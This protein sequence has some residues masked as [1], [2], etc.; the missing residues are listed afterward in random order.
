MSIAPYSETSEP[1]PPLAPARPARAVVAEPAPL[2][3]PKSFRTMARIGVAM[4]LHDKLK[5]AGILIGVVFS[6][7][8]SNFQT[9]LFLGLLL[10]NTMFVDRADADVWIVPPQ[11]NVLQGG[12]GTFSDTSVAAARAVTGV[13]WS[14]PLIMG[15]AP[16]RLPVGG[17]RPVTL[18][19]TQLPAAHGG[20]FHIVKGETASL[21]LPDAIF[22]DDARR[23]RLG[24][25]NLGSV[26]ELGGHRV[27]VVGFTSGLIPFGPSY[28]F[29]SF[30][31]A[32]EILRRANHDVNYVMVGLAPGADVA[33]VQRELAARFPDQK[34]L[35]RAEMRAATVD[36]VL[37]ES[38]IGK[39]IGMG[40]FMAVFC[41]FI[42]V[43]LTMFSAVVDHVREFGTL[44]AIG[45]TNRDLAKL[46]V[47]QAIFCAFVGVALGE[48]LVG[49][50][51][52]GARDAE[53][54]LGMPWWV[55]AATLAGMT[56]MCIGASTLALARIRK[57]EPAMVFRG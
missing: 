48:A 19:G 15:T 9:S 41:G 39:S 28:A 23:E 37:A 51:I 8:M 38:G 42:I 10:R 50:M 14:A 43:A 45:A 5:L 49:R 30:D 24:G 18:I 27:Q 2:L 12:D 44:K 7:V 4:L 56:L 46:L 36:F 32:R 17:Q 11:T 22:V 33:R 20:P 54:P 25:L 16:L 21:M 47:T 3:P 35:T 29:A 52:A 34:V 40:V 53:L 1:P 55:M 6:V 31:T 13:A 26:R 57:V